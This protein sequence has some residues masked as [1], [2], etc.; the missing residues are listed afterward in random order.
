MTPGIGEKSPRT[1]ALELHKLRWPMARIVRA[2]ETEATEE[3][4][5]EWLFGRRRAAAMARH[6]ICENCGE[7]FY[8]RQA[9][10]IGQRYCSPRCAGEGASKRVIGGYPP[11][12]EIV[13]LYVDERLTDRELGARFG[14]SYTWALKVRQHYRIPGRRKGERAKPPQSE[15][16]RWAISMKRETACRNCGTTG[17]LHLHHVVPRSLSP[18]GKYELR[19]GVALCTPCHLGWHNGHVVLYRDIFR[20]DEWD[21]IQTLIGSPWL[22][23]RYPERQQESIAA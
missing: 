22:D 4:I 17:F 19:N 7:G 5:C 23:R 12:D 11:R 13:R 3:Q 8:D 15:R 21:F 10:A 6:R 20:P 14:H 2:L 1:L 9:K 16:R 18:A